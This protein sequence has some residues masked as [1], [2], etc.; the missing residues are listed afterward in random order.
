MRLPTWFGKTRDEILELELS[1]DGV[2]LTLI[3]AH[4]STLSVASVL[5]REQIQQF[6]LDQ[7][8]FSTWMQSVS[9][10]ILPETTFRF[11]GNESG[12]VTLSPLLFS[13]KLK[14]G[15]H[16]PIRTEQASLF[17]F[18]PKEG[19]IRALK[20]RSAVGSPGAK[21]QG[22]QLKK[23]RI[24]VVDDSETIRTLL[25]RIINE[26]PQMECVATIETPGRVAEAIEKYKPD[27][28]TLDIHMPEMDGVTLLKVLLPKYLIPTVMISALSKEDG[29][30]VLDALEVGAVDY[31]QKPSLSELKTVAPVICEKLRNAGLARVRKYP[32]KAYGPNQNLPTLSSHDVDFSYLIGIGSSTGGIEALREVLTRLPDKIPPILIVQHIPPVF[33]K[34]FADR[35]NL[36]CPF[37]VKEGEDGDSITTERV[38]IAPGGK[39]MKVRSVNGD[40]KIVIDDSAPV[41]RHKPSVDVL[42]D[43][44]ALLNRKK[45]SAAILTGMGS[46]G[47][48]G[49][50][51]LKQNGA[52][53]FAQDEASSVVFG[54]PKEALKMG[55]ADEAVPLDQMAARILMACKFTKRETVP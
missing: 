42:F 2:M 33:S 54:M 45:I 17:Q 4:S 53:T 10:L 3:S 44:I 12:F 30:F 25:S 16:V 20:G 11:V 50:L 5:S 41:N 29:T 24:L 46:D 23:I 34:A 9:S 38:I 27:V 39:Q 32:E 52:R 19:R 31:I 26:D 13:L 37:E 51:K 8:L 18:I 7:R 1:P 22:P 49:L 36:L 35:L 28:I 47:A 48:R 15:K 55:G 43:S 40:L 21:N 6:A 14:E